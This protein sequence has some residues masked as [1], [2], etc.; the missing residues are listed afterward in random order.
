MNSQKK[1]KAIVSDGKNQNFY[2]GNNLSVSVELNAMGLENPH[3]ITIISDRVVAYFVAG[4]KEIFNFENN[5]IKNKFFK[6][7]KVEKED[8]IVFLVEII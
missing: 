7:E 8:E 1:L 5:V 3:Y 4:K 2:W 6:I